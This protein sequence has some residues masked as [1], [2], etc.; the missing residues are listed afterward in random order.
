MT[1][2][3]LKTLLV[4]FHENLNILKEREAKHGGMAPIELL[5]QIADHKQAI[6]LTEQAIVGELNEAGWRKALKP[7]LV[8]IEKRSDEAASSV[9]IGDIEGGVHSAKIAGRDIIEVHVGPQTPTSDTPRLLWLGL[10]GLLVGAVLMVGVV[11]L[12]ILMQPSNGSQVSLPE[13][14]ATP[15]PSMPRTSF[16][17]VLVV[18]FAQGDPQIGTD[19][20]QAMAA[21]L[22]KKF[23]EINPEA[24][25]LVW[26]PDKLCQ[27]ADQGQITSEEAAEKAAQA[28]NADVVV[29]GLFNEDN[30]IDLNFKL[31]S[32][33]HKYES[34]S[35]LEL[36]EEMIGVPVPLGEDPKDPFNQKTARE[37]LTINALI[38]ANILLGLGAY[39][40]SEPDFQEALVKF[41]TAVDIPGWADH[42]GKYIVFVLLG[43]AAGKIGN[44]DLAQASYQ[45]ASDIRPDFADAYL[46]LADVYF[47]Q[48]RRESPV[49][50]DLLKLA[51]DTYQKADEINRVSPSPDF[52]PRIQF[53]L[54]RCYLAQ[55]EAGDPTNRQLALNNFVEVIRAFDSG[56]QPR[57]KNFAAGSHYYLSL[58]YAYSKN[59]R[60]ELKECQAAL[61]IP[62]GLKPKDRSY[63]EQKKQQLEGQG[64]NA[65]Q[66]VPE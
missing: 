28:V 11:A 23:D 34:F 35:E 46:G 25:L 42:Q 16:I 33:L 54:G 12:I 15:C 37:K 41:Q 57:L 31:S 61:A 43:N 49:D 20:A 53:G 59:T 8:E 60:C 39:Y 66:C 19:L 24:D 3:E 5:H 55:V 52:I 47:V 58:I 40:K 30:K 9:T 2:A 51:I 26:G 64:V 36:A 14:T 6:A 63:C 10:V 4:K 29:Y 32:G 38:Y 50:S 56:Q 13:P 22:Q 45:K 18:D 27:G 21:E 44:L 17:N 1:E 48:A 7:L 62:G 65:S